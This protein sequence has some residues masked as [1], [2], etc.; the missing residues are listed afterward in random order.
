MD[1]LKY[2]EPMKNMPER[3]SNLAFWRGV[4]K[5]RDKMVD[6][7]EYLG[8]WGTGVEN[9][10]TSI[11]SRLTH[12]D[13]NID[14]IGSMASTTVSRLNRSF[15]SRDV[16]ITTNVLPN[17]YACPVPES[18]VPY[19]RVDQCIFTFISNNTLDISTSEIIESAYFT[20]SFVLD[21]NT[22]MFTQPVL[23]IPLYNQSNIQF[24]S[25]PI[26]LYRSGDSASMS[27]FNFTIKVRCRKIPS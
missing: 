13:N 4:R 19:P 11:E 7:F 15:E 23:L 9:N 24:M 18:K 16:T 22:I 12:I 6:T 8:V 5:L 1:L 17:I 14:S 25:P 3:F 21:G 20:G 2:L 10:L 27:N 26:P